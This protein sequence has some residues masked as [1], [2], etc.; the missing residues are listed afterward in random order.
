MPEAPIN[1]YASIVDI[2]E[3]LKCGAL[4]PITLTEYMLERIAA[5]APS[6][7]S[8]V[9]VTAGQ[10]IEQAKTVEKQL[11]AGEYLG[12]L[13][14]VPIAL[15]DLF[16]TKGVETEIGSTIYKGRLPEQDA[17]VVDKLKKSGAIVLG[18][19]AMTEFAAAG[20][21]PSKE[22]PKNPWNVQHGPGVSSGGSGAALAAGLCFG[23]LGTDTGGSIRMPSA[24]CG[25]V[26]LKPTYGLVSRSGVFPLSHTLGL[27]PVMGLG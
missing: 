5:L 23:S 1:P 17:F 7:N 27:Q 18:K 2:A 9:S 16:D 10:A 12:P 13:H 4:S 19:T 14:G 22:P 24:A 6:I 20:Y 26:G 8:Y 21:H 3:S 15:K 25:T 11:A